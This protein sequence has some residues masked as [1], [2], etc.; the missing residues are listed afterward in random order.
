MGYVVS[1][2]SRLDAAVQRRFN[3]ACFFLM[4]RFGVRKPMIRYALFALIIGCN[5]S[6]MFEETRLNVISTASWWTCGFNVVCMTLLQYLSL[7]DDRRTEKEGLSN[8]IERRLFFLL[9][10]LKILGVLSLIQQ[11]IV[12]KYPPKKYIAAGLTSG[13]HLFPTVAM[14]LLGAS[15]LAIFYLAKTPMNP[16]AEKAREHVGTPQPTPA[17]T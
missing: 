17:Q 14:I 11:L 7:R 5:F 4:S 3:S 10:S 6:F 1:F 13:E 9:P 16:P 15:L 2:L 8:E 12:L